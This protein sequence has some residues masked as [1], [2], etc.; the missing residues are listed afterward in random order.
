MLT[1]LLSSGAAAAE[2][3]TP[4]ALAVLQ[5]AL[6]HPA[7]LFGALK[8]VTADADAQVR[9]AAGKCYWALHAHCAAES[10]DFMAKLDPAQQ[11]MLK[12]CRPA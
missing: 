9:S 12:R 3:P 8:A 4:A 10:D 11:K 7:P 2:P 1:Q 5:H 6:A